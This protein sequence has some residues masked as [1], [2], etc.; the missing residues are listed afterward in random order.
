MIFD[1]LA[2]RYGDVWLVSLSRM[3]NEIE[4]ALKESS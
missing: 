3:W 1:R 4:Q 2:A